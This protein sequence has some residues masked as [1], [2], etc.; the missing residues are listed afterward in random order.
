[1]MAWI[2]GHSGVFAPRSQLR[3]VTGFTPSASA[4]A[5]AVTRFPARFPAQTRTSLT[6]RAVGLSSSFFGAM[7][8]TCSPLTALP[9]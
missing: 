5:S 8:E 4:N 9:K 3:T 6:Q 2:E 7:V 1:M